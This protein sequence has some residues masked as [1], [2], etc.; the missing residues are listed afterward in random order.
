[1][2]QE[3]MVPTLALL[4]FVSIGCWWWGK[5]ATFEQ[6]SPARFG[7]LL[8][9]AA[10]IAGGAWICFQP[11]KNALSREVG[12]GSLVWY[13]FDPVELERLHQAGIPVMLEFTADWCSNCK[14]N[15]V[16]VYNSEQIVELVHKKGV[17]PM[18][19]DLTGNSAR[20]KAGLRLR[21]LLSASSI[22]FLSVHPPGDQWM[23]PV[24]FYDIV[25]QSKLAKLLESFPDHA[26]G[27]K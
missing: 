4:L 22:P 2:K 10:I 13:E 20:T 1:V 14:T 23:H 19:V 25:Q 5:Y 6:T 21:D 27:S 3:L 8:T 7:T 26:S 12:S 16:F 17:V 11:L 18:R 24:R 15:E 9:A